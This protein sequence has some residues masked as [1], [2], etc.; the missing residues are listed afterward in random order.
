MAEQPSKSARVDSSDWF[1]RKAHDAVDKGKLRAGAP[2]WRRR[3]SL[4]SSSASCGLALS[5]T[6]ISAASR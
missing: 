3:M 5:A 6:V 4:C 1:H 2:H